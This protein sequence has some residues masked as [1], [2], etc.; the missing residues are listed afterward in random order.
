MAKK[1]TNKK[2]RNKQ[3]A[4]SSLNP[5]IPPP[6]AFPG[7]KRK[8]GAHLLAFTAVKLWKKRAPY[9]THFHHECWP[10][11]DRLES[12][13]LFYLAAHVGQ[14]T[15]ILS[16]AEETSEALSAHT[17][18]MVPLC[19]LCFHREGFVAC[20]PSLWPRKARTESLRGGHVVWGHLTLLQYI[21]RY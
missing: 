21:L 10:C 17:P 7:R 13:F 14:R 6:S 16:P 4:L 18:Q 9:I 15:R 20:T 3:K 5:N 19:S 1:Q 8:P 11:R 2:Q 12:E